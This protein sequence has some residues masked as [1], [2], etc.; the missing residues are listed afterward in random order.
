MSQWDVKTTELIEK[1]KR[2]V[3]D[4]HAFKYFPMV[5]SRA[6]GVKIWDTNGKE[7]IDFLS[8][9]ATFN[10][11]HSN[12]QVINV[13][14]ENLDKYLHHCFYIYHEPAI[15]LAEILVNLMPGNFAKKVAFGLSGSDALDTAIK[16]SL[17]YT[18][19]RNI[20]SFTYSYHGTTFMDIS[21]SGS[22]KPELRY[23]MSAYPNVH[24]FE[25]PDTYRR[26]NNMSEEE[27]GELCLEKIEKFFETILPGNAFAALVFEPIQGDGGVLVPP[28]NFVRGLYKLARD[29]GIC[30]I[31]DEVQTGLGRT[32]KMLAVEHFGVEP[33][34][35]VL[36]K[37]LGG[38]MP[39]SAVVGRKEILDSAPP[40]TFFM[41]LSPHALSSLAA[42][43]TLNFIMTENLLEKTREKG[44]YMM[45]R[46]QELEEKY[47]IIGD[48]RGLGLMLG[49]EI[50]EDKI[51][52]E[53]DRKEA[54]K[55]IWRAWE[56]G[57][58]IT[59]Y[60]KY[61]NVLRIAPPL[62]IEKEEIDK[63]IDILDTSIKDVIAG[64]VADEVF[65]LMKPW[66]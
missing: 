57:L 52:K 38:G 22:F 60:G 45:R 35:I 19:K 15:R 51:K 39:I 62:I 18:R 5:I 61:G 40:Q 36:G 11:G 43:A 30:F 14:A 66:C 65:D 31:D 2:Y 53:P 3:S 20:A 8:S 6:K 28:L 9:A 41:A 44:R 33:D 7:Y 64:K 48:V 16:A 55:I 37:A 59:T 47:E 23:N 10:V 54:V 46:L 63:A 42:I 1:Y 29:Y 49:I 32:G 4:G 34:L 12:Q 58:L 50:V 26:P 17:I 24:F 25:F 13:I 27:Y 56:K 21:V